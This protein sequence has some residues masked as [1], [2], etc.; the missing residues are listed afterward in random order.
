MGDIRGPSRE[1]LR[2]RPICRVG[3]AM[4]PA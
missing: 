3:G 2:R 4:V 1:D